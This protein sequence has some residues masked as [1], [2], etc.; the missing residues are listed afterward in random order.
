M[1]KREN[2][3]YTLRVKGGGMGCC[4]IRTDVFDVLKFPWF[5]WSDVRFD[6]NT[7][8]V[9]SCGEDIDFC[10]KCEQAGIPI[11]ADTRVECEHL[12]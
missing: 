5:V 10:E 1:E 12:R 7:G 11:Y 6:R 9:E 4:L 3:I 2:G 8:K